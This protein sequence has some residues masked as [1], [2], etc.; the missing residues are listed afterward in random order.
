M[1]L[2]L[3]VLLSIVLIAGSYSQSSGEADSYV[4]EGM[5]LVDEGKIEEGIKKIEKALKL[6]P[7]NAV[8]NYEL[9]FAY[10]RLQKFDKVIEILEPV[11]K[12]PDATDQ[13]YSVLGNAYDIIG[14]RDEA[15]K[16]YKAG[17]KK[18][19]NSGK[20]Y[21]EL[22][23]VAM[24]DKEYE[25]ALEYFEKGIAA[26][27]THPSNYYWA[28]I[29]YASSN[30]KLWG[31]IYGE[32]FLNLEINTNRSE[33]ISKVIYKI[34][35]DAVKVSSKD[36]KTNV[37][38]KL[39]SLP[40]D[41]NNTDD[42][43]FSMDYEMVTLFATLGVVNDSNFTG[44]NIGA[45]SKLRENFIKMWF[46]SEK[47]NTGS[48]VLFDYQK[49]LLDAE[50]LEPYNY[51]ICAFGDTDEFNKWVSANQERVNKFDAWFTENPLK[52]NKDNALY[53]KRSK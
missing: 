23:V 34:Y 51:F 3:T 12:Y 40:V 4:R 2:I 52:I 41:V 30:I 32:I 18:F 39:N 7:K 31:L 8:Y 53:R 10:Y 49:S 42:S 37:E 20:I 28:S 5:N 24:A 33:N 1:R 15:I 29:F 50:L 47:T 45:I 19:P 26:E 21:L 46:E 36:G 25:K 6:F 27:P 9:A 16:T 11:K 17:L 43:K 35:N 48:N 14:D 38:V 22:G 44:M 13:I